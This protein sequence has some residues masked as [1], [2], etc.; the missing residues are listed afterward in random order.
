MCQSMCSSG[1]ATEAV[2]VKQ[3]PVNKVNKLKTKRPLVITRFEIVEKCGFVWR[4]SVWAWLGLAWLPNHTKLVNF[5][6]I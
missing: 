2:F 4:G 3:G 6:N 5:T 1:S